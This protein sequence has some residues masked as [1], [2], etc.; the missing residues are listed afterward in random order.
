VSQ[1]ENWHYSSTAISKQEKRA[2]EIALEK[3]FWPTTRYKGKSE[4]WTVKC[5]ECNAVIQTTYRK[6][7][8]NNFNC[9]ICN[10]NFYEK[11]IMVMLSANLRPLEPYSGN[12][13]KIWK[14]Q[15]MLC[16]L[17]CFP[18][19]Y[20]VSKRGKGGCKPCS[21]IL[22]AESVSKAIEVMRAANLEPIKP[23]KN[24]FSPWKC[25]CLKCGEIVSPTMHNVQ[26]G[27]GGCVFCN[28]SAFKFSQPAYLY[29]IHHE[30]FAAFK[31]GIGNFN[32]VHDRIES[33]QISGWILL[34]KYSFEKG[35]QAYKIEKEILNWIRNEKGLP[36]YLTK[37]DF[38]HGGATETFSDDSITSL[39]IKNKI[40][41]A[42]KWL[43]PP[44]L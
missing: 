16:G 7:I 21:L 41:E 24:S 30:I 25:V 11:E 9:D 17:E 13:A 23:Y 6:F 26:R 29:L 18:R 14:S 40:E 42:I 8:L 20:D 39:E 2:V 33:H 31:V 43:Q 1:I 32:T 12:S 37:K 4:P 35:S 44:T 3:G 19:F 5:I 38:K 10:P 28:V 36:P 34:E 22:P 27:H 15:C